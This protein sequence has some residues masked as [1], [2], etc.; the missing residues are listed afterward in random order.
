MKPLVTQ[1]YIAIINGKETKFEADP[2]ASGNSSYS[3]EGMANRIV[4]ESGII[5]PRSN[6]EP[7]DVRIEGLKLIG[8]DFVRK[9]II[10]YK[11]VPPLT[12]MTEDEYNKEHDD[13]I[14]KLPVEF[15]GVVSSMAWERG[16]S[17]GYEEVIG[18][19][20]ELVDKLSPAIK[21]FERAIVN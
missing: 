9:H 3:I 4:R 7:V 19:L 5:T 18:I 1:L 11:I 15:H 13:L 10:S 6:P 14:S 20:S 21:A 8:G 12:R 2:T 17:A 16:H